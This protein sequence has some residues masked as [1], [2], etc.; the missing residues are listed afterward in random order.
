MANNALSCYKIFG[1]EDEI[2]QLYAKLSK[3]TNINSEYFRKFTKARLNNEPFPDYPPE[4]SETTPCLWLGDIVT[5]FGGNNEEVECRGTINH[6]DL[7]SDT[8]IWVVTDTAWV[9]MPEMWDLAIKDYPSLK[10]YYLSE[11]CGCEIYIN[12]DSTGEYFDALYNVD[13]MGIDSEDVASD[14]ELF[15]CVAMYLE[16]DKIDSFEELDRLIADYNEEN[17]ET[18][19]SY[20]K[21]VQP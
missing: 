14:K 18:I 13:H 2:S 17:S 19:I 12:S 10:F 11:E 8:I 4:I 6:L 20:H 9:P 5:Y 21:Y 1:E 16:I 15:W 7:L 3:L